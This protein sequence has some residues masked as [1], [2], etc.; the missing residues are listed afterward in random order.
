MATRTKRTKRE[1]AAHEKLMDKRRRKRLTRT[2]GGRRVFGKKIR[3]R[4]LRI[5]TQYADLLAKRARKAGMSIT[6][7]TL[8]IA[9]L[10]PK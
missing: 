8:R 3:S 4:M 10:N 9:K 5:S 2:V 7:Y 6:E 1:A